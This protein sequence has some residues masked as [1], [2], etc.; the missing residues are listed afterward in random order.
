[1]L[2]FVV[3]NKGSIKTLRI[4]LRRTKAKKIKT[5]QTHVRLLFYV[6]LADEK[7]GFA[8]AHLDRSNWF[9][10]V[11]FEAELVILKRPLIL[12]RRLMET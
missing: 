8:D 11:T 6:A 10:F 4:F 9:L 7:I 12:R 1:M 3:I 5:L 2:F